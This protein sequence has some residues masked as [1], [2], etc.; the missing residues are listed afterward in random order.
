MGCAESRPASGSKPS[1]Q[2][3]LST[4]FQDDDDAFSLPLTMGQQ[5]PPSASGTVQLASQHERLILELL[6]FQDIRQFHE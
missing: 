5:P 6:P 2:P 3:L 4:P 1:S